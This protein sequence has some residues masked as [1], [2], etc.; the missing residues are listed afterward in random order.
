MAKDLSFQYEGS[1]RQALSR[2]SFVAEPGSY[3]CLAGPNGSGKS[4]F[5][6]LACGL[7][8][9]QSHR[10]ELSW[11][12]TV[13]RDWSRLDLA[14]SVG[15]VA[16]SLKTQF[17]VTVLEFVLQGRYARSTGL[18]RRPGANDRAVAEASLERVG[19]AALAEASVSEISAGETQLT[20]IA[21]A[22]AQEPRALLLDE[23]TA[24]L[25][26]RHQLCVFELLAELNRGGMTIVVVSHDLNLA[27]EFCPNALWLKDGAVFSQG[28]LAE[29]LSTELM[30][31]LFEVGGRVEVGENPFTHRPKIFWR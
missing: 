8:H 22:L 16:G 29:T 6:K 20:M 31:E 9:G 28:S 21:R 26:L 18:W 4:T 14:R 11:N 23:A 30:G 2:L 5:L 13:V 25:D 19:I 1:S 17:P 24:N 7:L 27:A 12:G 3:W 10:G 15:F